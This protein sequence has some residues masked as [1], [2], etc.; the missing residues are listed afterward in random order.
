MRRLP[1][2][3]SAVSVLLESRWLDGVVVEANAAGGEFLVEFDDDFE[4]PA[5]CSVGQQWRR[6]DGADEEDELAVDDA[7]AASQQDAPILPLPP[8]PPTVGEAKDTELQ[9]PQADERQ[10]DNTGLHAALY[11]EFTQLYEHV[12][13]SDGYGAETAAQTRRRFERLC[14]NVHVV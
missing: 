9:E 1:A 4:V 8:P 11:T 2:V 14:T 10:H 6:L 5:W 3:G 7:E 12:Q 13:K